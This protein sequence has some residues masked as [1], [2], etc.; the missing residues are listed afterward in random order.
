MPPVETEI[1][2][3]G[4]RHL[5]RWE[6]G[7][8]VAVD[9]GDDADAEDALAALGGERPPCLALRAAWRQRAGEPEVV[10]LGRRPGEPSLGLEVTAGDGRLRVGVGDRR[11]DLVALFSLPAPFLDRLAIEAMAS[12]ASRWSDP[13]FRNTHGLRL[14]AALVARARPALTRLAQRLPDPVVTRPACEPAA[15][16]SPATILA[17]REPGRR[18]ALVVT[19][20]LPLD[21]LSRV[22]GPGLSEPSDHFVLEVEGLRPD[23]ALRVQVASWV[24]AGEGRWQVVGQPAELRPRDEGGWQ[25]DPLR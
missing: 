18:D 3:G 8:L 5:L 19:A 9:H 14:G 4:A 17:E 10:T 23:G 22:W 2:C 25:V 21:W 15:T 24:P 13:E 16:G 11:H 7:A 6:E 20:T 1:D 12:A